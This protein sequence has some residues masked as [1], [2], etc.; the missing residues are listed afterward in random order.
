VK[1]LGSKIEMTQKLTEAIFHE[2]LC[3][4]KQLLKNIHP[5]MFSIIFVQ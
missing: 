4:S 5:I 1:C 2:R 3:H